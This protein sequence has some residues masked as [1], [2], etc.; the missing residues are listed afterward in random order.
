MG[1][2]VNS[3]VGS[4]AAQRLTPAATN[5]PFDTVDVEQAGPLCWLTLDRPDKGN[6]LNPHVLD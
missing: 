3:D 6:A 2:L 4:E 5:L 1:L